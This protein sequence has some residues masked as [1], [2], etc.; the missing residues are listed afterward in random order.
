MGKLSRTAGM[1]SIIALF[2]VGCDKPFEIE[3]PF[4]VT[5]KTVR[6]KAQ[7][8]VTP[9]IVYASDDWTATLTDEVEWA[10]I[11]RLQGHGLSEIKFAYSQN[12][13]AARKVGIVFK[14]GKELPDT[15]MMIQNAGNEDPQFQ[16]ADGETVAPNLKGEIKLGFVTDLIY[17]VQDIEYN[18][19][20]GQEDAVGWLKDIRINTDGVLCNIDG[21]TSGIDRSATLTL[22]HTDAN[23]KVM[24]TY[25]VIRQTT[26]APAIEIDNSII[27]NGME[28]IAQKV[29]LPL[30]G[31]MDAYIDKIVVTTEYEGTQTDWI[32]D[33]TV[34]RQLLAFTV[35]NNE[36]KEDRTADII[37]TYTDGDG[38]PYVFRT[39]VRQN[40]YVKEYTFEDLKALIPGESGE[41]VI[42]E[43]N[44][45]TLSAVVIG[46][47]GNENMDINPNTAPRAVDWT[48]NPVTNYI[49]NEDGTSGLRIKCAAE[50]DNV[51]KRYSRIVLDLT[52][53][54]LVKEAA[55]ARYTLYNV[56]AGNVLTNEEGDSDNVPSKTKTI[57]ELTDDDV[58]TFT[59]LKNLEMTFKYGAYTNCH[60]GYSLNTA[61]NPK[62]TNP[63]FYDAVP[64]SLRDADGNSLYMVTNMKTPWR[65]T[66]KGVVQGSADFSGIIVN[67]NLIRYA[68]DGDLGKYSIRI[69]EEEDI[70]GTGSRFSKTLVEWNWSGQTTNLTTPTTGNGTLSF[71]LD[72]TTVGT[73][74]EFNALDANT[75]SKGSVSNGSI[76]FKRGYWWDDEKNEAPYF[77]IEFSTAGVSGNSLV[78]NWSVGQGNGGG[79]AITAPAYWHIE[80][81]TDQVNYTKL[82]REYAVR[83]LV[84]WNNNLSLSAIPGLHEYT[85]TLPSS[86]FG[87][88]KVSVK[89]VASSKTAA[90]ANA[91]TEGTIGTNG[92]NRIKFGDIA[93]EYN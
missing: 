4:G 50:T 53:M 16:F 63:P 30:S 74:G 18:I 93:V 88:E 65:R 40:K 6:L 26:G 61:T 48:G 59:T 42:D 25:M 47:A 87:K 49:Q 12:F 90:T 68:K 5:T 29:E 15:V 81:S 56:T 28:S 69:L 84:W 82:D 17:D 8:G 31:N 89:I 58:Y 10:S 70:A 39:T 32:S 80:Y 75:G 85:T 22:L 20:Y 1:V 78:F 36:I 45:G 24:S 79:N 77:L 34:S 37:L 54:R 11:D 76:M 19:E 44:E 92:E 35:S 83:P 72:G 2:A 64:S 43:T 51:F 13:G 23:D 41:V 91:D 60:D 73:D 38:I 55:P 33:I 46:D 71:S 3:Q 57:G 62:G 67:C 7:A 66:G 14:T 27:A 52:G 86:L 21:N 9:V